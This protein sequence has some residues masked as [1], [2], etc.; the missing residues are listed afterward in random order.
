MV[1]AVISKAGMVALM[2]FR[3]PQTACV[4]VGLVVLGVAATV[5]MGGAKGSCHGDEELGEDAGAGVALVTKVAGALNGEFVLYLERVV[6]QLVRGESEHAA[7]VGEDGTT[8]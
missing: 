7:G 5:V 4:G 2:M 8:D 3:R 6:G 1:V